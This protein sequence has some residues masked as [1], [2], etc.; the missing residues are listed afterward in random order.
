MRKISKQNPANSLSLLSLA[1]LMTLAT[2]SEPTHAECVINNPKEYV[3]AVQEQPQDGNPAIECLA[4]PGPPC[5]VPDVP[6][7]VGSV[8]A[9]D[10]TIQATMPSSY[11]AVVVHAQVREEVAGGARIFYYT[12]KSSAVIPAS[13]STVQLGLPGL[14]KDTKHWV[15]VAFCKNLTSYPGLKSCNCWSNELLVDTTSAGFS[16]SKPT[17]PPETTGTSLKLEDEFVRPTT[18][19]QTTPNEAGGGG[20][21]LGP[22]AVWLDGWDPPTLEGSYID[23]SG[24]NAVISNGLV[25]YTRPAKSTDSYA[26]T[27]FWVTNK[28]TPPG[29]AASY[30]V[31]VM[32]RH[33][34]D[35]TSTQFFAAKLV[36]KQ[37]G[38]NTYPALALLRE[39]Q[40]AADGFVDFAA[41]TPN[42]D[43]IDLTGSGVGSNCPGETTNKC[44]GTPPLLTGANRTT[45]YAVLQIS[46]KRDQAN[47]KT[48]LVAAVGWNCD[49]AGSGSVY[50][51]SN[52]CC[53]EKSDFDINRVDING[54]FSIFGHHSN[55]LYKLEWVRFGDTSS[56]TWP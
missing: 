49:G 17:G 23:T 4:P 50:K 53:L 52:V 42:V 8:G 7:L 18:T 21:G 46:A 39:D 2:T 48:D 44:N 11:P 25:R 19:T 26:A 32:A 28:S 38:R 35:G 51:C 47:S 5:A 33:T 36:H 56:G 41:L 20:D 30:N 14:R 6:T 27:R 40:V 55:I 16:S 12:T 13:G 31:E 24:D 34:G 22:N 3:V 45:N 1:A 37:L 54:Q 9:Q 15:S 29:I 10:A 43:Y